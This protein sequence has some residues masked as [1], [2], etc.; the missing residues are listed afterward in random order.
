MTKIDKSNS[1]LLLATRFDN[2]GGWT[3]E[4]QFVLQ[5][6]SSYLLA[7]GIGTPIADDPTTKVNIEK[8]GKYTLWVRTKNWTAFWSEGK[9][10]GIFQVKVD[11]VADEA[12]FG[13]GCEGATRA[14]RAAWYWQKGG[15]YELTAGEHEI[16]LHDVMGLDGRCDALLL[17]T[18]DEAPDN[19]IE[20]YKALRAELLPTPIE[21][22]GHYDFVIVGAGISGMCAALAAARLGCKVA[23][24]QDRYILGGNNSSEVRVGLGGQINIDPYPSLGYLLNEIGP[25]R[26]G[27]AR[28]AHHYQD[29]KKMR[30][31]LAEE[32][33]TLFT[34]YT[35]TEVEKDGEKIKAVTAVEATDQTK[36]RI[37][38]DLFSDCTGDAHLAAMAGAECRM[39]REAQAEFGENLLRRKPTDSQWEC[40]SSGT[41]RTGTHHAPS[42][43]LLTGDLNWM[44]T[45][46]NLFTELTGTGKWECAMI[47]LQMPKRSV[48]TVC[49]WPTVHSLTARTVL[50]RRRT[51]SAL[52]SHGSAMSAESARAVA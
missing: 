52:I 26:I 35:V 7:H 39:G 24:I 49:M 41:V 16:A 50:Q 37:S 51:G 36:I 20:Y 10:P 45:Q 6:G 30:V 14:E 8:P 5:M 19:T 18:A 43:I 32:N 29:D 46:L 15:T 33:I 12:E 47:R 9:T 1:V 23:L 40:R 2:L 38:G 3:V 28:G 27:N 17:T 48:T 21:E 22:K 34:G 31:I 11:G 25:D 42:L 44:N 13:V 4:Q